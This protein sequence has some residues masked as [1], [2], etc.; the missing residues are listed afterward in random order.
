MS[1]AEVREKHIL[2]TDLASCPGKQLLPSFALPMDEDCMT[3]N[4]FRPKLKDM[5]KVPVA[6]YI[7]GG[8]FNRGSCMHSRFSGIGLKLTNN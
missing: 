3:L 2:N 7:H 8:A 4:V 5:K 1:L 6:V